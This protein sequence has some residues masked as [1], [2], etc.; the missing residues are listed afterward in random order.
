MFLAIT[1]TLIRIEINP[2]SSFISHF[3]KPFQEASVIFMS[4]KHQKCLHSPSGGA[5]TSSST[6][7][8]PKYQ[9][10]CVHTTLSPSCSLD[11]QEAQLSGRSLGLGVRAESESWL[12]RLEQAASL[13]QTSAIKWKY[14]HLSWFV[15]TNTTDYAA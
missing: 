14:L 2:S 10:L 12:Y 15:I 8:F 7:V 11:L 1:C 3:S 13:P 4:L 9:V 6:L 5:Q